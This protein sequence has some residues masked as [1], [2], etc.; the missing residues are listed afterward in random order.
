V[1]NKIMSLSHLTVVHDDCG[2]AETPAQRVRRLQ[3]EARAI[4]RQQ[5]QGFEEALEEVAALA[6]EIALGG[7]AYPVG[8]RQ[9]AEQLASELP[10]KAHTLQALRTR[11]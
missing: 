3:E 1:E 10:A 6:E 11:N 4:A 2:R 9:L 7:D 5:I 8:V